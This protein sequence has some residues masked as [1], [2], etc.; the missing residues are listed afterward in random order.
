MRRRRGISASRLSATQSSSAPLTEYRMMTD[1]HKG[2]VSRAF[3]SAALT[4]ASQAAAQEKSKAV[5]D[6]RTKITKLWGADHWQLQNKEL[7]KGLGDI[8][9]HLSAVCRESS[10]WSPSRLR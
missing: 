4:S 1:L 6:A 3:H 2:S 9:G 8:K 7:Q 10:R 5:E